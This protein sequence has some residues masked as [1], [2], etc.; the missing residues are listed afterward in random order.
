MLLCNDHRPDRFRR[1]YRRA[2]ILNRFRAAAGASGKS[3]AKYRIHGIPDCAPI[4]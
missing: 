3:F 4:R 1:L 2:G